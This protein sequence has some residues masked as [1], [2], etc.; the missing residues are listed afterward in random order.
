MLVRKKKVLVWGRAKKYQKFLK[1]IQTKM[2]EPNALVQA[3][4]F[5]LMKNQINDKNETKIGILT[6]V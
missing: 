5:L 4:G 6:N 3:H 2:S 1:L